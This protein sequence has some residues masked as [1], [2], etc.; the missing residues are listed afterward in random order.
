MSAEKLAELRTAL[1]GPDGGY[2][3]VQGRIGQY[4]A[5]LAWVGDDERRAVIELDGHDFRERTKAQASAD[6]RRDREMAIAG[7]P[8]HRFTGSDVYKDPF[9]VADF[10]ARLTKGST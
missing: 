1:S 6:K 7:W 2:V 8:V 4:R 10:V 9:V 3:L 5:D